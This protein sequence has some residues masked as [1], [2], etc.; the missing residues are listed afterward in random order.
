MKP[1]YKIKE[2]KKT[3]K[4]R[5]CN[6]CGKRIKNDGNIYCGHCWFKRYFEAGGSITVTN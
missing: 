4:T 1:E 2:Y 3:P 5:K 6:D